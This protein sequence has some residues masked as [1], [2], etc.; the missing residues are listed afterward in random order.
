MIIK[1]DRSYFNQTL[2]DNG[3]ARLAVHSLHID[4]FFTEAEREMNAQLYS[5]MTDA[6][7]NDHCNKFRSAMATQ[8]ALLIH[9]ANDYFLRTTGKA[10]CQ[11]DQLDWQ[12]I[13]TRR[14]HKD[15]HMWLWYNSD[16]SFFS[17]TACDYD[18]LHTDPEIIPAVIEYFKR[19]NAD[20]MSCRIQYT[21]IVDE[22]A[23]EKE[24]HKL[25]TFCFQDRWVSYNGIIGKV[26]KD[27]NRPGRY[28]F[29]KKYS[30]KWAH[31]LS[32]LQLV[33]SVSYFA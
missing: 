4:R 3:L 21:G 15:Y 7:W 20:N 22:D 31:E 18:W 25:Y 12:D 11:F 1:E 8:N 13:N 9:A 33:T 29:M 19:I 2:I 10:L 24:A 27:P 16:P 17:L 23:V 6:E 5:T 26:H 30:K 28:Y 14:E 32:P